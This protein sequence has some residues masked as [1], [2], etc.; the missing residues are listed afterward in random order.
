MTAV[1]KKICP[2]EVFLHEPIRVGTVLEVNEHG[3]VINIDSFG[4][5]EYFCS[6][7]SE[8]FDEHFELIKEA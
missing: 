4:A 8:Y 1:C 2:T 6:I 3:L 7:D 5:S